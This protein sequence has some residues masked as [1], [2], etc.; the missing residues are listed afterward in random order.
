VNLVF[1]GREWYREFH[2]QDYENSGDELE[3]EDDLGNCT[4]CEH[5]SY[6]TGGCLNRAS[7]C[8]KFKKK[9]EV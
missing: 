6:C 4:K 9:E 1:K 3:H 2:E 7:H 5:N 8:W